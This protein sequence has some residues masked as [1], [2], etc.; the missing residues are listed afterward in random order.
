MMLHFLKVT[1]ELFGLQP[2]GQKPDRPPN[3]ELRA[4]CENSSESSCLFVQQL[5]ALSKKNQRDGKDAQRAMN[6]L[7]HVTATGLPLEDFYDKKQCHVAHEFSYLGV[8]CKI[9]RIRQGAV[10]IYFSYAQEKVIYLAAVAAKRKDKLSKSE[11]DIL[12]QEI[13]LYL[14]AEANHSLVEVELQQ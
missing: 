9:W 10:R 7:F 5:V 1:S 3:W 6:K 4:R 8:F 14:N 13:T 2:V 11:K 12:E